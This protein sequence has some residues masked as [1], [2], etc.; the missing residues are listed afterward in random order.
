MVNDAALACSDR[1]KYVDDLSIV[2]V[3]HKSQQSQMQAH[4]N[5]LDVWCQENDMKLKQEKCKLMQI[6]FLR[7]PPPVVRPVV[8]NTPM[9]V[10]TSFKLLGII[11]QNDLKWNLQVKRMVSNASRRLFILCKLKRNGVKTNDLVS[12]YTMYIR[13]LLEFGAPVWSLV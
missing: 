12:I 8:H 11:F 13:P 7:E 1:W 5:S 4:L 10:V 6:S 2:E 9:E 3:L